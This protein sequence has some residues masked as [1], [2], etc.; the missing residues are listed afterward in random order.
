VSDHP[1]P[2]GGHPPP[3]VATIDGLTVDLV[4]LA[5]E[6]C[7]L[8]YREFPD[9]HE[10][11]GDAG[12]QWCRH[13]NQWLLSWAVSDVLGLTV[14]AEQAAW[15]A[16]VL[17]ARN[18]PVERLIRDLELAAEVARVGVVGPSSDRVAVVLAQ[19]AESVAALGLGSPTASD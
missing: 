18:F 10:R 12:T 17:H 19:A 15:L 5:D 4:A 9:E 1:H 13:D 14:L 7:E 2:P 3:T 8:Y 16:G 11:S 6:V